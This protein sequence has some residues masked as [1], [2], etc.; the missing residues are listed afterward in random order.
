MLDDLL[1]GRVGTVWV[2][3]GLAEKCANRENTASLAADRLAAISIEEWKGIATRSGCEVVF[4]AESTTHGIREVLSEA[5]LQSEGFVAVGVA[6]TTSQAALLQSLPI[7]VACLLWPQWRPQA[8][9]IWRE[10]LRHFVKTEVNSAEPLGSLLIGTDP[11]VDALRFITAMD[12]ESAASYV[13]LPSLGPACD[14]PRETAL[15]GL[16]SLG[17]S[18]FA[19]KFDHSL[20]KAGLLLVHG[21]LEASHSIAQD[22]GGPDGDYWHGIMHR[23]E[24]DDSNAKYWF[25]RVG[26]HPIFPALARSAMEIDEH[27]GTDFTQSVAHA[28]EWDAFAFVDLCSRARRSDDSNLTAYCQLV[29]WSEILLLLN[30][31]C[32]TSADGGS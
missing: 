7:R 2:T 18:A 32:G 31:A 20:V 5:I 25:R 29:Q 24:P 26:D 15:N 23:R 22:V 27:C 10:G 11:E 14:H 30:R 13:T 12:A 6:P 17:D 19:G 4:V 16:G 28:G 9:G 3:T 8:I 21:E 1:S